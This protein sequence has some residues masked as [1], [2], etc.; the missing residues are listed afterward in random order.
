ML[1]GNALDSAVFV[2][3]ARKRDTQI[4]SHPK[5]RAGAV[6]RLPDEDVYEG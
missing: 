2:L 6:W 1:V 4:S 3:Q 5:L